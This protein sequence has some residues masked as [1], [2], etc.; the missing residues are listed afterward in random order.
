V[1]VV[2][3]CLQLIDYIRT[4]AQK[5]HGKCAMRFPDVMVSDSTMVLRLMT[6]IGWPQRAGR[7]IFSHKKDQQKNM[8]H[9]EC[10]L[11]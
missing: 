6:S 8:V 7:S 5:H 1:W 10:V 9:K 3:G 2:V 11:L 4:K